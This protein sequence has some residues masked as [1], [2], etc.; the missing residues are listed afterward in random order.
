MRTGRRFL[1]KTMKVDWFFILLVL[2]LMCCGVTLVYSATYNP[3][4]VFYQ[5]FWFRQI[6]Y[7]IVGSFIAAGLAFIRI[8]YLKRLALPFYF[9]SLIDHYALS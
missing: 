7:F 1:D 9:L 8:D 5:S 6:V 3:D 4:E 2:A